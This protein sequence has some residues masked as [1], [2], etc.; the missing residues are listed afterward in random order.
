LV[1]KHPTISKEEMEGI[2]EECYER[3]FEALGYS[4]I[5]MAKICLNRYNVS[6]NMDSPVA[7]V[8]AE[9][10]LEFVEKSLMLF[11]TAIALAPNENAKEET[12][13]LEEE[14]VATLKNLGRSY[15]KELI[16]GK[17]LL[18]FARAL[19]LKYKIFGHKLEQPKYSRIEYPN[20]NCIPIPT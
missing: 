16:A 2:C 8:R 18:T 12:K 19:K 4:V 7:R 3:E 15:K 14:I 11:P 20:E 13:K 6:K 10:G 5:R 1:F 9:A 17:A